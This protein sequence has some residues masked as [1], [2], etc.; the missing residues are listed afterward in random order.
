MTRTDT[1]T[2][3]LESFRARVAPLRPVRVVGRVRRLLDN[4]IEVAGLSG[5]AS[6]GDELVIGAA[7][8]TLRAEVVALDPDTVTAM[9]CGPTDGLRIGA[10]VECA[11]PPALTPSDGWLGRIVDPFGRPL[12]DRPLAPGRRRALHADPPSPGARGGFG[13][14]LATGYI[15]L[16]TMLPVTEGQRLGV[17]AGSG[18]GKS[19]LLGDLARRMEADVVVIALVGERGRE[20]SGFARDVLGREGMARTVIVAATSDRA[21]NVR[22]RCVPAALAVA[23]HFRDR[24]LRVLLLADSLTRHAEAH[25]DVVAA[26]TGTDPG[27]M[28]AGLASDLAALVERAGPGEGGKPGITA[29]LTVL[30][31]G[32]DMEEPVADTVRGLLDG[33]VVLS[34][35]IAESGRYPAIDILASVSR[36]LPDCASDPENAA[37]VAARRTL[38]TLRRNELMIT[39]GLYEAGRDPA[40]DDALKRRDRLEGVLAGRS[41][42]IPESF[43]ALNG[44]VG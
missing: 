44:A 28:P 21:A 38:E 11:G 5:T 4:R 33:H 10:R 35:A 39:S 41:E 31:A 24:G 12:D 16:D 14:R 23:E 6:L 19:R 29:V 2:P 17:F 37:I 30:V 13:P 8:G 34:R 40:I 15:A 32:S 25:R 26:T 22:R 27:P 7:P 1:L 42:G 18:V 3:A 20:V 9:P 43:A 36:A